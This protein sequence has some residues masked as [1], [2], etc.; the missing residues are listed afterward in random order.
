MKTANL[1]ALIAW[2]WDVYAHAHRD[3]RNL[4][5]HI[6]AVPLFAVGAAT[7]LA[8]IVAFAGS[9]V[10]AGVLGMALG[11]ALQGFGH[12]YERNAP[13]PFAS[14]GEFF[15]RILTEQFVIFPRFVLSG[16]WLRSV[17]TPAR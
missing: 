8:G 12:R 4:L 3:R 16:A 14:R 13:P 5:I 9:L 7:L 15:T 1:R 10:T 6:V 17:R 2:Q 11:F